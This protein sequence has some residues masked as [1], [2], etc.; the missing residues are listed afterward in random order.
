MSEYIEE[1][2]RVIICRGPEM[3]ECNR[4]D[5]GI[6]WCFVCRKRVQFWQILKMASFEDLV[7]SMGFYSHS[8]SMECERGHVNGDMFPGTWREWDE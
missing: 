8:R 6:K 7:A 2:G 1:H 3:H 4:W 5:E